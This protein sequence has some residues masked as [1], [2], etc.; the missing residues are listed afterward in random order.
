[1]SEPEPQADVPFQ[2]F[3]KEILYIVSDIVNK[4]VVS[5]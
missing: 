1:M 3:M 4:N 2:E 5:G